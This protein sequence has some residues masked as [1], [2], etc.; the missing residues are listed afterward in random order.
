MHKNPPI[1]YGTKISSRCDAAL[2]PRANSVPRLTRRKER[3]GLTLLEIIIAIAIMALSITTA[4]GYIMQNVRKNRQ[5]SMAVAGLQAIN[6][7]VGDIEDLADSA[8]QDE[9]L[10]HA[11][12]DHFAGRLG[13]KI[14]IGPQR[15][16]MDRMD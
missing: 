14:E 13:E 15:T 6:E 3:A 4:A 8:A 5:M 11:V 10:A 2:L 9:T 16:E 12:V 1:A 7:V